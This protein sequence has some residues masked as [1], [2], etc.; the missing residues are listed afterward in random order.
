M[1]L[2]R[3][4]LG[5]DSL[6]LGGARFLA[7][8]LARWRAEA[9]GIDVSSSRLL[10][11]TFGN[12]WGNQRMSRQGSTLD[13]SVR[14]ATDWDMPSNLAALG[15]Y[16][17]RL[18]IIRNLNN[19]FGKGLHGS[20][21][22]TLSVAPTDGRSPG[23]ISFDRFMAKEIG[24]NDPFSSIALGISPKKG[25]PALSTSADGFRRPYPALA[26][27]LV[28][29][30]KIFGAAKAG[31]FETENALLDAVS[32]DV[33]KIRS[34]LAGP[35]Q[36]K[37]DQYVEG[38]GSIGKQLVARKKILEQRGQPPAPKASY[39]LGLDKAVMQAH[40]EVAGL[41]LAYGLTRVAHISLMGFNDHNAGWASLGFPE[42]AHEQI[43][44]VSGVSAEYSANAYNSIVQFQAKELA[45]LI[46][47]LA[48]VKENEKPLS[49]R[50]TVVWLN[51]A[52][53]KHH[54]GGNTHPC[55]V[56]GPSQG[57]L[58]LGRYVDLKEKTKT[59]SELFL[60][61]AQSC[62]SA[63]TSFGAPEA[64]KEPL[65]ELL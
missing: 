57:K 39:T 3:R 47:R 28:A 48:T 18:S 37:L 59:V 42:D 31:S 16:K 63:A 12:G 13:T 44:H 43:A 27:P 14:T 65:S 15:A 7:P 58:R 52:G 29:F 5:R 22:S 1:T 35:E 50:L 19:P 30:E 46:A 40:F 32:A 36:S 17:N 10:V 6:W 26:S 21:W 2:S 24:K 23:G 38:I 55:V 45:A 20:G 34:S 9:M 11:L 53:G 41:A 25:M 56:L 61:V 33:K 60:A 51:S 4:A 8:A 64:C 54:D 62:G 49:E